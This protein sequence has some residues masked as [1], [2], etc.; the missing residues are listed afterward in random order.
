ML[1][2]MLWGCTGTAVVV[3]AYDSTS[4]SSNGAINGYGSVTFADG[5]ELRVSGID[6]YFYP[7]TYHIFDHRNLP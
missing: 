3:G 5:S 6:A 4:P 2:G 7:N 1:I